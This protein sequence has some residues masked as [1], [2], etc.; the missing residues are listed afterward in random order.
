MLTGVQDY[1]SDGEVVLRVSNGHELVC[2]LCFL[3]SSAGTPHRKPHSL[4]IQLGVI[5]GSGCMTG[6]LVT[7]YCAAARL[8]Y[9]KQ[10]ELFEDASQ[11]V[12][13]DMLLGAL[14]G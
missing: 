2:V 13:G 3:K 11:L 8:A 12:Q 9:L 7:T 6:T 14:A 4:I 1:I 10:N 5:T